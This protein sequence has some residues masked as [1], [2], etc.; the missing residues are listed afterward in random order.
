MDPIIIIKALADETRLRIVNILMRHELSVNE[1]VSVLDMGQSRI[2]RHLKILSDSGILRCRKDGLWVFYSAAKDNASAELLRLLSGMMDGRD[3]FKGDILLL[4]KHMNDRNRMGEEYFNK[5]A[6]RWRD[7]RKEMLPGI[8]INTGILKLM[9][10]ALCAA[11]LGCGNGELTGL[12]LQKS[13]R[14]I[15]VDRSPSMLNIAKEALRQHIPGR[16]EFRLGELTNLPLRNNEADCAIINMVLHYLD[17]PQRA[18]DEAARVLKK[19]GRLI[20]AD[21]LTHNN[22]EM[23]QRFGHRWL[24]FSIESIT[25]I[26]TVAGFRVDAEELYTAGNGL[27]AFIV[28]AVKKQGINNQE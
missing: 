10:K 7:L 21:L 5:I 25:A 4:N 20:I 19:N 14:V 16:A 9:R 13:E 26:L 11:D 15:G 8:D 12:L 18:A 6:P 2:S 22:E 23:R 3:I 27:E 17:D 24:G 1:L 28:A